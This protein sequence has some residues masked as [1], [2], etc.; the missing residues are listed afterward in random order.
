MKKINIA[1][2]SFGNI[3]RAI[4][5]IHQEHLAK[6]GKENDIHIVGVIRRNAGGK[7]TGIPAGIPVVSD[8]SALKVKPDVILCA[9][10]SGHVKD[11]V[12]KFLNLGFNTVDC[13]DSHPKI[14]AYREEIGK[15]ARK[16]KT[17]SILST[18]WDPGFDSVQRTLFAQ[19]S[20]MGETF[21][22]F[23][24][25]RSM[26]HTTEVKDIR[27]VR[28]AVSL[29]LP[30]KKPGMQKRLVYVVADKVEQKRIEREIK[31]HPYFVND[32]TQVKFVSSIAKFDTDKHQ[33]H[34]VNR[35]TN[36]KVE[37]TLAGKNPVM[38]ANMMYA[39]ARAAFRAAS[40]SAFG[41]FTMVERPPLDFI[42][43]DTVKERLERVKY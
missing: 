32:P 17:V 25:G 15:V 35:G 19:L 30:G 27:G 43:G 21:T 18:G 22:T 4:L 5:K 24:P 39:S 28:D 13:F 11:D 9:G 1:I 33:G 41:C 8:V 26:G 14:I 34:L 10:P 29:T 3:G 6:F 36:V 40:E 31:N 12:K 42:K 7:N 2:S 37:I 20:P 16:N 23:G 38:T